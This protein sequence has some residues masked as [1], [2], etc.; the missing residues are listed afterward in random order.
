[1]PLYHHQVEA[2]RRLPEGGGYLA[3]E[4]GLGKTLTAIEYAYKYQLSRVLVVCPATVIGVWPQELRD[5]D[6]GGYAPHYSTYRWSTPGGTRKQKAEQIYYHAEQGSADHLFIIINYEVLLD[7]VVE[8][9]IKKWNPDLIIFDEA[10]KVKTATAKRSKSAHRLGK[11]FPTLLLSGTPVTRN[12][13]D[14]YSQYKIIDPDIWDGISWTAFKQK[15]GIWGGYLNYELKGYQPGM[16]EWIKEKIAP[17]TVIARKEDTLDLPAKTWQHIPVPLGGAAWREYR[18]MA[19]TGVTGEWVTSTPLEVALRLA[20]LTARAKR[21]ATVDWVTNLVDQGEQVVVYARFL[22][23]VDFLAD[24]LANG[25]SIQGKTPQATRTYLVRR[26]QGEEDHQD[27]VI[28]G[29]ISAMSTGITLTAASNM[30]YH[31]LSYEY[32][33]WSQSQDRI[34][35]MGMKDRPANY[36]YMTAKG[37]NGGRLIDDLVVRAVENKEDVAGLITRDPSLLIPKEDA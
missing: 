10:H 16:V 25:H 37:P 35:R 24:A 6:K 1:M 34:H 21:S 9:A 14:L 26:F 33:H 2:L 12:L 23:D 29:Q 4:Q 8:R 27:P 18:Q 28:V 5:H 11:R 31:G 7:P 32:E 30:V 20:Q 19:T 13:L 36:Y 22:E 17:W 3:F 15:V